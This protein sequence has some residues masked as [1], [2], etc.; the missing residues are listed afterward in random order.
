MNTRTHIKTVAAFVLT[1]LAHPGF[2]QAVT[3]W[4]TP[5]SY[6]GPGEFFGPG[7]Y[8]EKQDLFPVTIRNMVWL[9]ERDFVTPF[10]NNGK[11]APNTC[12]EKAFKKTA[13]GTM[14]NGAKMNENVDLCVMEAA[15]VRF[16]PAIP[17][18]GHYGGRQFTVAAQD[19][20]VVMTMDLVL[21]MGIGERGIIKLPFYGTTGEV[22]VPT[23]LQTQQGKS[24]IDQAGRLMAG[25]K[26]RG[27]IG[28]FNGDGW[29][30]GTLVAV[31]TLPL[32]SPVFPGQP[33][34]M[35]RN[36]ETD[37]PIEGSVFGSVK[38]IKTKYSPAATLEKH[39]S[40]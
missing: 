24:G 32:D 31:G 5:Q 19:G 39:A 12:A 21:D 25:T 35:Y 15:G 13:D 9:T 2:A 17:E 29:I 4:S 18:A 8:V 11:A 16:M 27:R 6:L 36:F 37:I 22:T 26:I 34:A 33:Y 10:R 30:D 3:L 28:D 40:R 7:A 1:V 23:S 20:N 38:A 14:S